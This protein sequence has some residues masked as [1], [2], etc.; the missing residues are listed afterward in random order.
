MPKPEKLLSHFGFK[1]NLT[2]GNYEL[3][4]V[5]SSHNIIKRFDEYSYDIELTF[6]PLKDSDYNELYHKLLGM[7][8]SPKIIKGIR[9]PYKCRIYQ[10]YDIVELNN[11][12]IIFYLNGHAKRVY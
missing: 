9:N 11:S 10:P 3:K 5:K 4:E 1:R 2:L 7:I 6:R 8:K 12:D